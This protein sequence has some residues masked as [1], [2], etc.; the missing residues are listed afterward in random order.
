MY[1]FFGLAIK[2]IFRTRPFLFL[3]H[4]TVI[5]AISARSALVNTYIYYLWRPEPRP[6]VIIVT[7]HVCQLAPLP[8]PLGLPPRGT[9]RLQRPRETRQ[10]YFP[11]VLCVYYGQRS[12]CLRSRSLVPFSSDVHRAASGQP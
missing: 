11:S 5:P 8:R 1:T 3:G 6:P 4:P 12:D 10:L 7:A 2:V 9:K